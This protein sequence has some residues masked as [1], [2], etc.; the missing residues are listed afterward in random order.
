MRTGVG[1]V[2]V[3]AVVV[4]MALLL[5]VALVVGASIKGAL[6]AIATT[7]VIMLIGFVTGSGR[8]S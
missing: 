7:G 8:P 1:P 5:L 2:H 4:P 3:M 6:A